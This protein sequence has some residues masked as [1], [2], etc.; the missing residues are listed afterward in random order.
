MTGDNV[1]AGTSTR[2]ADLFFFDGESTFKERRRRDAISQ[3]V[4]TMLAHSPLALTP[5]LRFSASE[6][7][8]VDRR[9]YSSDSQTINIYRRGNDSTFDYLINA[10]GIDF[11]AGNLIVHMISQSLLE[12]TCELK[13]R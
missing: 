3:N 12:I 13:L 7:A 4:K 10:A 2:Q 1:I 8:I 11:R 6:R 5:F 9:L